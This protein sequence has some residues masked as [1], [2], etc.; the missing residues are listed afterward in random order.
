M[1]TIND[2]SERLSL[3]ALSM[4]LRHAAGEHNPSFPGKLSLVLIMIPSFQ[5]CSCLLHNFQVLQQMK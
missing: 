1:G 4:L 2:A 5:L 3:S